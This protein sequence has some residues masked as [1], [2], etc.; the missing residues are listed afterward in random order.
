[1]ARRFPSDGNFD[2]YVFMHLF[3]PG[4][5]LRG[6]VQKVGD[7]ARRLPSGFVGQFV[8]SYAAFARLE[9]SSFEELQGLIAGDL[10]EAG[11]R[12]EWST[13]VASSRLALP[14]RGSPDYCAL[15]RIRTQNPF[16]LLESLDNKFEELIGDDY[17]YG[18]AV[19][20]G[21][22]DLLV[23]LGRP[24]FEELKSALVDDLRGVDGVASSE[25]S[26]A[27]LPGNALSFEDGVENAF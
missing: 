22:Y 15:V 20:N 19:V 7:V 16:S 27:Y 10:W 3:E 26:F 4:Q 5:S 8:G 18:A 1:M 2:A 23:D 13:N 6:A 21:K 12:S 17:W 11:V 14:K 24:S 25:A 9:V